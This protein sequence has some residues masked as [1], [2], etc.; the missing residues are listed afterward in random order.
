MK[1]VTQFPAGRN[2]S[3][4]SPFRAMFEGAA[5]GIAICQLDGRI[6]E[7]NAALARMLGCDPSAMASDRGSETARRDLDPANF[8]PAQALSEKVLLE[9]LLPEKELLRELIHGEREALKLDKR[10]RRRDGSEFYGQ[11]TLS[12]GRDDGHEP[13]FL[14]LVLADDTERKR[15]EERLCAAEKTEIIGRLAG[16]IAHDFNNLLTGILLYCDLVSTGLEN[17]TLGLRELTRHIEEVRL[18][19]EQGAGLTQQLLAMAR[20]EVTEPVPIVI[21]EIIAGTRNL[22][23]RLIGEHVELV[24]SLESREQMVLADPGQI[25][26]LLLNLVL[27]ARDALPHGGRITVTTRV[28]GGPGQAEAAG[29]QHCVLL[30]VKD[31]GCGM[32]RETR[33]RLFEPLFTTKNPGKGTGLGLATVSRIVGEAGGRIVVESEMGRGT[34]IEVLLPAIEG[35]QSKHPVARPLAATAND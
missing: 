26:Q 31:N 19:G 3:R 20:K 18:A 12:L 24:M 2:G 10:I 30:A 33:G 22:L 35:N 13:A 8:R 4:K 16:A 5:A 21:G 6:L 17:G 11:A 14:I 1:P 15:M 34:S 9:Q 29:T 23:R 25:R 27:N 28:V 7:T 32:D